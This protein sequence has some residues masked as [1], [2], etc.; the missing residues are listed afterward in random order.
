MPR[1]AFNSFSVLSPS[2]WEDITAT[3]EA[4]DPPFTIARNDGV[5]ALQFS[6]ASYAGGQVPSPSPDDLLDILSSFGQAH[7][8]GYPGDVVLESGPLRLASGSFTSSEDFVRAW[9]LSDGQNFAFITYT[10]ELGQ[11]DRELGVCEAIVRS[12]QFLRTGARGENG[13]KVDILNYR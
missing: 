5:G 2:D 13:R 6:I 12:L 8:F 3:I 10:C 9:Q 4:D 7:G 1:I 11:E